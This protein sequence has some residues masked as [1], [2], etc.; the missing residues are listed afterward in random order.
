MTWPTRYQ[1]IDAKSVANILKIKIFNLIHDSRGGISPWPPLLIPEPPNRHG[2][3]LLWYWR[4]TTNG[5]LQRSWSIGKYHFY[6][7]FWSKPANYRCNLKSPSW[8]FN[9]LHDWFEIFFKKGCNFCGMVALKNQTCCC[10]AW[11][12]PPQTRILCPV[13]LPLSNIQSINF[14]NSQITRCNQIIDPAW[15][16]SRY[17]VA[18]PV[19]FNLTAFIRSLNILAIRISFQND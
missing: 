12:H 1:S 15:V 2:D 6:P 11:K 7:D 16:Q 19:L 4:N 5:G 3:H 8:L 9:F 14:M 10:G 18:W 17:V 13:H